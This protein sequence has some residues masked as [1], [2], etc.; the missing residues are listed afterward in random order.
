MRN[1]SSG[2]CGRFEWWGGNGSRNI[3]GLGLMTFRLDCGRTTKHSSSSN[4]CPYLGVKFF[5]FNHVL[6]PSAPPFWMACRRSN[7][8]RRGSCRN[9][10]VWARLGQS[11]H[12]H[13]RD[14]VCGGRACTEFRSDLPRRHHWSSGLQQGF[15]D[16]MNLLFWQHL[17]FRCTSCTILAQ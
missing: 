2:R 9:Y 10:T 16:I 4:I 15:W 3:L 7:Q 5:S 8:I 17:V 6:F 14:V 11:M 12:D 1:G 13:G